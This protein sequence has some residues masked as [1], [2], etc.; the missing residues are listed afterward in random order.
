MQWGCL[1]GGRVNLQSSDSLSEIAAFG[2]DLND[3]DLLNSA[4]I[5]TAMDN[6][7]AETKA[8]AYYICGDCDNDGAAKWLKANVL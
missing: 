2:D 3:I 8:A 5:G 7:L 1:N 6:A 4:G